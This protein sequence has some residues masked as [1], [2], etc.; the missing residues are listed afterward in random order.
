[1]LPTARVAYR[2]LQRG[3]ATNMAVVSK[4]VI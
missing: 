4:T 1:M 2:V 3:A